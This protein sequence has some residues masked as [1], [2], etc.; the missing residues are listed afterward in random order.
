MPIAG[1]L[2]RIGDRRA[3]DPLVRLLGD[4]DIKVRHAAIGALNSIGHPDMAARMEEL[5][6]N[7]DP[8]VRESAVKIAGYFGYAPCADGLVERCQDAEE[9]VRA[10]ALEHIAFLDDERVVPTLVAA[11]GAGHAAGARG[12]RAA[13]WRTSTAARRSPRSAAP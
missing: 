9:T 1:A 10:A 13:R 2:A 7:P 8:L 5:V 11:L 4:E 3:F 12:G 6:G